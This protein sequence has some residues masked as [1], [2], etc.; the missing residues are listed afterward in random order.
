MLCEENLCV[1]E[2]LSLDTCQKDRGLWVGD[3]FVGHASV[4]QSSQRITA[5]L[6]TAPTFPRKLHESICSD[7]L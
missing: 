2:F 3:C 1:T 7:T 4:R 6:D 5:A